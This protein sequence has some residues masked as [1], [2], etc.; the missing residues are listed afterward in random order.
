MFLI[1][2]QVSQEAKTEISPTSILCVCE[3]QK[4]NEP[5]FF[6]EADLY[7]QSI[8]DFVP[9]LDFVMSMAL[10]RHP[11]YSDKMLVF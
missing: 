3:H 4:F 5:I 2:D 10:K 9:Y 8:F 7:T 6:L 1:N 11:Y